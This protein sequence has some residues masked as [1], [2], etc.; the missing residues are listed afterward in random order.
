MPSNRVSDY[1][2]SGATRNEDKP[3]SCEVKRDKGIRKE[4][5]NSGMSKNASSPSELWGEN[6]MRRNRNERS[7]VSATICLH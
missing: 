1:H 4:N 7:R 6:H 2:A 3:D 5:D